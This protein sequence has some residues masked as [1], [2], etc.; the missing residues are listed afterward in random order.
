MNT[1]HAKAT[2]RSAVTQPHP[3]DTHTPQR[4]L[5]R[6][7][8]RYKQ[9]HVKTGTALGELDHPSYASDF[10]RVLNVPNISHQVGTHWQPHR[11]D[12]RSGR[13][14]EPLSCGRPRGHS[15]R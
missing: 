13:S 7:V 15:M 11:R 6:E 3:R 8:R 12:L 14:T 1:A 10:F 4:L 9:Q 5:V 2:M